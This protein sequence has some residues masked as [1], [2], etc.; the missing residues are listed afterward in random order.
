MEHDGV[1]KAV[2][3]A[4]DDTLRCAS[5][6][7]Q[8]CNVYTGTPWQ[9]VGSNDA[10]VVSNDDPVEMGCP[11]WISDDGKDACYELGCYS[12]ISAQQLNFAEPVYTFDYSMGAD[13]EGNVYKCNSG[14]RKCMVNTAGT[15]FKFTEIA[16]VD[17][18]AIQMYPAETFTAEVPD[19]DF[20]TSGNKVIFTRSDGRLQHMMPFAPD[21]QQ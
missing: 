21:S 18:P 3:C 11:G 4:G 10:P 2:Q 6:N 19:G 5:D 17:V 9:A 13:T 1:G 20:S 7:G 12:E 16:S 14:Y 15:R 8:D